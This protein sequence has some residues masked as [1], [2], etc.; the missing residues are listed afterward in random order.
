MLVFG[1]G[2][3]L[4]RKFRFLFAYGMNEIL[5]KVICVQRLEKAGI[6]EYFTYNHR[7]NPLKPMCITK[8]TLSN[9]TFCPHSVFVCV[10]W[11]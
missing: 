10:V 5:N 3:F 9:S 2:Y 8:L 7:T 4:K 11:I 6:N 1:G